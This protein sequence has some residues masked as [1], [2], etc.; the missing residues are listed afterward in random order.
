[1][2]R[3]A[4]QRRLGQIEG[5][6]STTVMWNETGAVKSG[7]I[8]RETRFPSDLSEWVLSGPH[9][10]VGI[11]LFKTPSA[12]C[13]QNGDYDVLDLTQVSDDYL[14]RTNYVPNCTTATYRQRV[15]GVSWNEESKVT[16]YY[17]I[18]NREMLNQ[19][20]ERTFL[21]AIVPKS[22][23]HVNTLFGIVFKDLHQLV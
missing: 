4:D 3:F 7:T 5:D 22:V 18:V 21:A 14:P 16:D 1:L 23:G 15:P 2:R 19:A 8:R 6:Y 10:S 17:R 11:P 9:I 12:R 13:V 20:G